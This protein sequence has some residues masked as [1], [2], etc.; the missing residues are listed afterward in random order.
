[1]LR[2]TM[3]Y[4]NAELFLILKHC[5]RIL[6]LLTLLSYS[7]S[8][9]NVEV[10]QFKAKPIT[11][12][13]V[14][15]DVAPMITIV[16]TDSRIVFRVLY[17]FYVFSDLF[18]LSWNYVILSSMLLIWFLKLFTSFNFFSSFR[19]KLQSDL[20]KAADGQK[21]SVICSLYVV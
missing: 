6:C 2:Y 7:Q 1:M 12:G 17:F 5:R 21:F 11:D 10:H 13:V 8:Y 16:S 14:E 19:S 18:F 9:N 3:S 20:I 15:V 4:Y